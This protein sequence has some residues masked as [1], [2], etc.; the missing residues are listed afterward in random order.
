[1]II[2]FGQKQTY[3]AIGVVG[4]LQVLLQPYKS[5][6]GTKML[7]EGVKV[8]F[9]CVICHYIFNLWCAMTRYVWRLRLPVEGIIRSLFYV[10]VFL[11]CFFLQSSWEC[12][13]MCMCIL[14]VRLCLLLFFS[15]H[16][17]RPAIYWEFCLASLQVR[18][19][20]WFVMC[21]EFLPPFWKCNW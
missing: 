9:L 5:E 17:V 4:L 18:T 19:G 3:K 10:C 21:V 15:L 16:Y 2:P 1:M 13:S 8:F 6:W 7:R 20:W 11:W 14:S 12:D